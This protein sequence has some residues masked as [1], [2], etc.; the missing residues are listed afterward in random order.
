[1]EEFLAA[2]VGAIVGS[3]S[4]GAISYCLQRSALAEAKRERKEHANQNNLALAHALIFKMLLMVN[5]LAHLQRHVAACEARAAAADTNTPPVGFLQPIINIADPV[6][7]D[8]NQMS[9]LLAQGADDVFNRVL[10]IPQIHN[11]IL[12]VWRQYAAMR[13]DLH[14]TAPPSIDMKTGTGEFRVAN[15]GPQ[16][17][18][19]FETNAVASELVSRAHR[20][21]ADADQT[22]QSLVKLLQ[23]NLRI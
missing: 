14:Q 12:S 19:F 13:A 23:N 17:V 16:A 5:N 18:K 8:A 21:Y 7:L 11:S 9:M 1:M 22:L 10:E 3:V 20:D 2:I 6:H 4:G 15:N